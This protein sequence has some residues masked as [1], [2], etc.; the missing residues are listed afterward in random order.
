MFNE[1]WCF[2]IGKASDIFL[3]VLL[4]LYPFWSILKLFGDTDGWPDW[5]VCLSMCNLLFLPA[6]SIILSFSLLAVSPK[7]VSELVLSEHLT[8]YVRPCLC[9]SF[10]WSFMLN[11]E[12]SLLPLY[13]CFL[14][15]QDKGRG[16]VIKDKGKYSEKCMNILNTKRFCKL[17]EDPTKTILM[18]I[19]RAVRKI[20]NELFPKEY[21]NI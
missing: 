9:S 11:A 4:L 20:K 15:C 21:L 6:C 14:Q 18:K 5:S 10:V 12:P 13:T 8:K 17:Q 19:Q 3:F 7:Y 2:L 1:D 16:I